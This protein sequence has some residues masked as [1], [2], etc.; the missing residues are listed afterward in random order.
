[1]KTENRWFTEIGLATLIK[2]K[3]TNKHQATAKVNI[4]LKINHSQRGVKIYLRKSAT[5][6][7][8]QE[9]WIL[10]KKLDV[11]IRYPFKQK[12]Y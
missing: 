4:W 12:V 8:E 9:K 7:K 2:C 3:Q 6:R 10:N 11:K 5:K 1:M